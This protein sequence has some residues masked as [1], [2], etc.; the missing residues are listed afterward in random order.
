MSKQPE[1]ERRY[2]D[3]ELALI[4]KLAAE[5]QAAP[6]PSDHYG[7]SLTEIQQ[8]AA[9]AGIDPQHVAEAAAA[10][11]AHYGHRKFSLL[12]APTKFLFDRTITG[13]VSKTE[14]SEMIELIPQ[15]TGIQGQASQIFDSVEWRSKDVW[16][17]V[18]YVTIRS[19][20]GQTKIKVLGHWWGPALV[21]Y[22][23]TGL[24]GFLATVILA[25]SFLDP[26]S[27]ASVVALVA[28]VI[29]GTYLA[30]RTIWQRIARKAE[31]KLRELVRRIEETVPTAAAS[32]ANAAVEVEPQRLP[33][34]PDEI[35]SPR[36]LA[37]P[38]QRS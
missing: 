7:L 23:V 38:P 31:S 18:L 11:E 5:R 14:L 2:N 9:E 33:E 20:K 26:A 3:K 30:A 12:G 16:D 25:K 21:A 29:G 35:T 15:V 19:Q 17:R 28:G 8:I 6:S 22:L 1:I 13:E 37:S 27:S 24:G 10:L 4:L 34:Q 32:E 36:P